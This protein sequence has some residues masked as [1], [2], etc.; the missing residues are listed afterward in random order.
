MGSTVSSKSHAHLLDST[1][2]K[3]QQRCYKEH[4][5][6]YIREVIIWTSPQLLQEQKILMKYS[7]W[8]PDRISSHTETLPVSSLP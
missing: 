5:Y 4:V 8:W 7:R 3:R 6:A 1:H 2:L